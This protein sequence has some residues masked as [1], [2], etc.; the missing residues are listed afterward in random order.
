LIASGL[1]HYALFRPLR[2]LVVMARA[3]GHGDFSTRLRLR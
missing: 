2:R 1:A 3:V